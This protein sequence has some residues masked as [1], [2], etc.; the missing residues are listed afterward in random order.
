LACCVVVAAAV[1]GGG[2]GAGAGL[3]FQLQGWLIDV[4]P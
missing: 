1:G 3:L 2:D 4:A